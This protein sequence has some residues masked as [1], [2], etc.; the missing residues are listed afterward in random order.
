M[1]ILAHARVKIS[2]AWRHKQAL[3]LARKR[4]GIIV[5]NSAARM[6]AA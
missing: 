3:A 2:L 5:N 1:I 4:N 6:R